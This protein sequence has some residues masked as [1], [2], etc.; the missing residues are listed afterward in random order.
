MKN[1]KKIILLAVS[2]FFLYGCEL[3]LL[4]LGAGGGIVGYQYLE[5]HTS[6][7][8]P[9][10]YSKAW[11]ASNTALENL[12]ISIST[13]ENKDTQANI[14]GFTKDG[15]SVSIKLKERGQWVTTISVRVGKLG[16]REAAEKIL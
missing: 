15:K 11:D 10:E 2:F 6:K 3:A 9:L 12:K 8:F 13:S 14:E 5:G 16:N 1:T 7:E 4:G